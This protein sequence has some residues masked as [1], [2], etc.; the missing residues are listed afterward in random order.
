VSESMGSENARQKNDRKATGGI[1]RV[2][3]CMHFW[4]HHDLGFRGRY[5]AGGANGAWVE[6]D[7]TAARPFIRI[8][9]ASWR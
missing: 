8:V 5:H 6:V 9:D 4:L 1:A 3:R 2:V 7:P